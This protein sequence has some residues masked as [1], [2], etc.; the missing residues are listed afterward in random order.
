MKKIAILLA[1]CLP[2]SASATP[3]TQSNIYQL[4]AQYAYNLSRPC[5][6]QP[7]AWTTIACTGTGVSAESPSLHQWSSY[8]FY[9]PQNSAFRTG[10]NATTA[11]PTTSDGVL[12]AGATLRI[13]TTDT[14]LFIGCLPQ[15]TQAGCFIQE[16]L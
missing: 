6:I 2:L 13:P 9:C 16:C 15:A 12:P 7:G 8:L 4:P 10:T 5:V 14:L 1:F 3:I 11:T